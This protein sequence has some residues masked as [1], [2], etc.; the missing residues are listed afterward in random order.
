MAAPLPAADRADFLAAGLGADAATLG[1]LG[2]PHLHVEALAVDLDGGGALDQWLGVV[3]GSG[4][5]LWRLDTRQVELLLDPL[6]RVLHRL[7]VG[8]AQDG[9]V[10]GDGGGHALDDHLLE[11]ADGAG[12]GRRVDPCPTR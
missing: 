5:R 8:V 1:A 6:R 9:E 2:H 7:E 10:G 12:D 3:V 4:R 11:G